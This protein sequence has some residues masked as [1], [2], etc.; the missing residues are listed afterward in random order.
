M[1]QYS[2]ALPSNTPQEL[3]VNVGEN[4]NGE[5]EAHREETPNEDGEIAIQAEENNDQENRRLYSPD[6][7]FDGFSTRSFYDSI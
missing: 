7:P 6:D 4:A 5:L 2:R 1:V 3:V